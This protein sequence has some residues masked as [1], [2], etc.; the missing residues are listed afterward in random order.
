MSGELWR[1]NPDDPFS[2][3]IHVTKDGLIGINVGGTV[4]VHSIYE[5]H[6]VMWLRENSPSNAELKQWIKNPPNQPEE[7][8][9]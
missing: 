8:P 5:W 7:R 2:P 1:E 4:Y 3:S 9:W 6:S